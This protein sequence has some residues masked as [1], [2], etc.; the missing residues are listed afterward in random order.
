M[1][2]YN[3]FGENYD[4][5]MA[6]IVDRRQALITKAKEN[7]PG[8]LGA[9]LAASEDGHVFHEL[10]WVEVPNPI[11]GSSEAE[12]PVRPALMCARGNPEAEDEEDITD[13]GAYILMIDGRLP[14]GEERR[15]G[16]ISFLLRDGVLKYEPSIVLNMGPD[17]NGITGPVRWD[18]ADSELFLQ[19][20]EAA[21]SNQS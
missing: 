12:I 15:M 20:A 2:Y 18:S 16:E 9:L 5:E 11:E 3:R 10:E 6:R 21:M 13:E 7:E 4:Q 19:V 14:S 8:D 17:H 1:A